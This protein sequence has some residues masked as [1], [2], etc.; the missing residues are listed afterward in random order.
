M[1]D[2]IESPFFGRRQSS[3]FSEESVPKTFRTEKNFFSQL[4]AFGKYTGLPWSTKGR[5]VNLPKCM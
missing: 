3:E 5:R 1:D 4:T 2:F